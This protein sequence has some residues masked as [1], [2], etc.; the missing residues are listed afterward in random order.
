MGCCHVSGDSHNGKNLVRQFSMSRTM[1]RY[2]VGQ[3]GAFKPHHQF[4]IYKGLPRII[5]IVR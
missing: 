1:I 2:L 5:E 4:G 3:P